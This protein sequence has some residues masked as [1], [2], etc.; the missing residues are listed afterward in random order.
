M[1]NPTSFATM[2]ALGFASPPALAQTADATA[3]TAVGSGTAAICSQACLAIAARTAFQARSVVPL[4]TVADDL[5]KRLSGASGPIKHHDAYWLGYADYQTALVGLT[6]RQPDFARAALIEADRVLAD[7]PFPDDEIYALRSLTLGL[8]MAITPAADRAALFGR[9]AEAV[10]KVGAT[11]DENI[12]VLFAKASFDFYTPRQYGG[13]TKAEALLR[14]ALLLPDRP[15][16]VLRPTWGKG[17]CVALLAKL[18]T[19]SGRATEASTLLAEWK[20]KLSDSIALQ[21]TGSR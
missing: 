18:L 6:L 16:S 8:Q 4:T 5:R 1:R 17:D 21:A 10:G 3:P 2:L 12:R 19:A 9:Q 11:G 20:P 14:Q 15:P 13:G 7:A